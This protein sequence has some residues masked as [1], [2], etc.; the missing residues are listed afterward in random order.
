MPELQALSTLS[1]IASVVRAIFVVVPAELLAFLG[2]RTPAATPTTPV[3]TTPV[4]STPRRRVAPPT[5]V[6]PTSSASASPA[7]FHPGPLS[8]PPS[9]RQSAVDDG[10]G[11]ELF[12][13]MSSYL[14]PL[15]T[16]KLIAVSSRMSS[17]VPTRSNSPTEPHG[18]GAGI[19]GDSALLASVLAD[20]RDLSPVNPQTVGRYFSHPVGEWSGS[21]AALTATL[22][23]NIDRLGSLGES[24]EREQ[25]HLEIALHWHCLS[26]LEKTNVLDAVV[27]QLGTRLTPGGAISDW[28]LHM[29][30]ATPA[31]QSAVLLEACAAS[32]QQRLGK[33]FE[34]AGDQTILKQL[35]KH[36]RNTNPL[37]H[38]FDYGG[39]MET[40]GRVYGTLPPLVAKQHNVCIVGAGPAGIVA[41]DGLNRLGV[42]VTVLEQ[43]PEIGGRLKTVRL[44]PHD[45]DNKEEDDSE[46]DSATGRP[47]SPTPLEMG[48]MRYAP[49]DGNSFYRLIQLY[50]L[51][52]LPFPNPS[53]VA[54]SYLVG[55]DVYD[56]GPGEAPTHEV[57]VKVK[58]DYNK[59][60]GALLD[61]VMA[62]RAA[63]D[64]VKLHALCDAVICRF[65]KH[66]FQ[67][68]L[69]ELLSDQGIQWTMREWDVF[70]AIGIGVGGYEGYYTTGFLEEFRFLADQRLEDHVFL[71]GGANSVLHAVVNDTPSNAR[72]SLA[73]Q[74][75]IRLETEV[76]RIVRKSVASPG[77]DGAGS[78]DVTMLDKRKGTTTTETFTEVVFAAGPSE[79]IRLGLTGPQPGSEPLMPDDLAMA[80]R[81][82]NLVGATK[83]A[84][85]V[86]LSAFS[87]L[88][89]PNNIQSSQ[90]FQQVYVLPAVK[91]ATSRTIF[92]SYQL[93]DNATKTAAMDGQQQ[94]ELFVN[95]IRN[96]A[97]RDPENPAYAKL[98]RFADVLEMGKVRLEFAAW[99]QEK[100]FGG[101]FKMDRPMQAGNTQCLWRSTLSP[102]NGAIF[103]NEMMTAEGGFASGAVSAAING[104]QQ[105][106][107]K[108]GGTLP[109]NSPLQQQLL[110]QTGG[111]QSSSEI[112]SR[113]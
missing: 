20:G 47:V 23:H 7:K 43:G 24:R 33:F 54:T 17:A 64:A 57:M 1:L 80:M 75:A 82:A 42:K 40:T 32:T 86:P 49:F 27:C 74:G 37:D 28:V 62:A 110:Y 61:P 10:A 63:C 12:L 83:L 93:G 79:A 66:T 65:D 105:F 52:T 109:P 2:L 73:D 25:L 22:V 44:P 6:V 21:R 99:S 84:V 18:P 53:T 45:V 103:L 113:I 71:P 101:A 92:L 59:A 15:A 60:M 111:A 29:V 31:A 55:N 78:Y 13:A 9:P 16:R 11:V 14:F 91:G 35:Y 77:L 58:A 97:L 19:H 98:G 104:V 88:D 30:L 100:H 67:S 8:L 89:L 4:S 72:T 90:P 41:A 85:K 38:L 39:F 34:H 81:R 95:I 106:I 3:Q 68:G 102:R 87:G 56:V 112:A 94:F 76:V 5:L 36:L 26:L 96:A 108:N 51:P 50:G 69:N 70:G 48:G 107:V 46:N